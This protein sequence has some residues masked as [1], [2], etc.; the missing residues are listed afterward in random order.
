MPQRSK[1][2]FESLGINKIIL[3]NE[4]QFQKKSCVVGHQLE[5]NF[6]GLQ[7]RHMKQTCK[8]ILL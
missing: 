7:E 6:K 1:T 3:F 8:L 4:K 5:N 2:L